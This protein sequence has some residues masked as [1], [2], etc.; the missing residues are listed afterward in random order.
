MK[1]TLLTLLIIGLLPV[2]S[3]LAQSFKL[4]GE[5]RP[6]SEYRNGYKTLNGADTDPAFFISQRSR[7]NLDY[8]SS[9]VKVGLSLQ[10]VRVWGEAP[11]LNRNDGLSSI[12][13]AWGEVIFTKRISLKTGR[14]ELVYDD[15]RIF[16]SVGWAQQARSHDAAILKYEGKSSKLHIGAAYNQN[17]ERLYASVYELANYKTLQYIWLNQKIEHFAVSLLFLN[18]GKDVYPTDTPV[19]PDVKNNVFKT[20]YSQTIGGR[21]T[22]KFGGLKANAA[23]Y[24]QMGEDGANHDINANYF[25]LDASLAINKQ[26]TAGL[27]YEYL[28]G[29]AS[30]DKAVEGYDNTSF[31]PL[32]GT[33]HK[34]NGHM[35][36]FYV[37]NHANGVGLKD[38]Y[39]FLKYSKNKF[40][41]KG[42][43]HFFATAADLQDAET[44]VVDAN[45]GTEID[46]SCGYKL[47][48]ISAISIGYSHMFGT[49]SMEILKGGNADETS[50]WL[51]VMLSFKPT[52]FKTKKAKQ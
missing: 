48:K 49:E 40:N 45:L 28:S 30:A 24:H 3:V 6:R 47:S 11:Q 20:Q 15:H 21:V 8:M 1:K 4:S 17:K 39:G 27:G 41:T 12:H 14:Q 51:W 16:G 13:Q 25:A 37:G 31:M 10:D 42:T 44:N 9:K 23:F 52:F 5:I 19:N 36:Y 22:S 2:G 34:F 38:T 29:T 26:F 7:L 43:I 35:D 46:L 32:Y 18:N 33:N 50:N